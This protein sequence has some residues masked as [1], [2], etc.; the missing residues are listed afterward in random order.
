MTL[1]PLPTAK[2]SSK[3]RSHQTALLSSPLSWIPRCNSRLRQPQSATPPA[4]GCT[5]Q[6]PLAMIPWFSAI[7]CPVPCYS[8]RALG[9]SA[10]TSLRIRTPRILSWDARCLPMPPRPSC[11]R[12]NAPASHASAQL[13]PSICGGNAP[14]S[15]SWR[16]SSTPGPAGFGLPD[17]QNITSSDVVVEFLEFL[18]ADIA[19]LVLGSQFPHAGSILRRKTQFQNIAG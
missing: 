19:S 15:I 8:S 13:R 6:V 9:A 18:V 1:P 16:R 14:S 7:T 5:C 2:D 17:G 4:R 11:S 12:P 3:L 10:T